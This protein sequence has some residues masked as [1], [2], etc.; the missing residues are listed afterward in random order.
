MSIKETALEVL[1]AGE[2]IRATE[3]VAQVV[4]NGFASGAVWRVIGQIKGE[5]ER[6]GVERVP[7]PGGWGYRMAADP[8]ADPDETEAITPD[9]IHEVA[10]VVLDEQPQ[11]EF[12]KLALWIAE[13]MQRIELESPASPLTRKKVH[14]AIYAGFIA[15]GRVERGDRGMYRKRLAVEDEPSDDSEDGGGDGAGGD[16]GGVGGGG[17]SVSG[18][19]DEKAYY[20]PFAAYLR[21]TLLEC[22]GAKDV[23]RI[24]FGKGWENPDV[25]GLAVGNEG[26]GVRYTELVSAEVKK[27]RNVEELMKG[28][29]QACA[30]M[31]FSH[32]VYY[33]VVPAPPTVHDPMRWWTDNHEVRLTDLCHGL[34]IGLVVADP[35]EDLDK[36]QF[37]LRT[38][39]RNQPPVMSELNRYLGKLRK[40]GG[41]TRAGRLAEFGLSE[42]EE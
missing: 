17:G 20:G 35:D 2:T 25:I 37:T 28:F 19:S 13:V 23:H 3:W 40:N 34:G 42:N 15:D 24:G 21:D 14:A 7:I 32:K 29:G 11:G 31:R 6:H 41:G 12:I 36:L 4:E 39:A 33:L 18:D 8:A 38:R 5:M 9:K 26:D 16:S 30:Y 22:D 10:E 1:S 27:A